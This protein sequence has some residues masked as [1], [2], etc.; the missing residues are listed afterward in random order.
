MDSRLPRSALCRS[1]I[2]PTNNSE[3][4][5]WKGQREP[6][7][8]REKRRVNW[9]GNGACNSF[10]RRAAERQFGYRADEVVSEPIYILIPSEL[11]EEEEGILA[12]P[13]A[14]GSGAEP[15]EVVPACRT[16]DSVG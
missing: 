2:L 13:Y 11:I 16:R 4:L 14:V 9:Q 15:V 8:P 6:G 5:F 7:F 3:N 12:R 10:F 1:M